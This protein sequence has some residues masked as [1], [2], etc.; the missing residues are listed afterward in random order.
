MVLSLSGNKRISDLPL[1]VQ[2]RMKAKYEGIDTL[3]NSELIALIIGSGT[4]KANALTLATNL[5]ESHITLLNLGKIS[6]PE[7]LLE[8][9]IGEAVALRLL[10]T[11]EIARRI[12]KSYETEVALLYERNSIIR[13]YVRKLSPL[14]KEQ[15]YVLFLN[16]NEIILKEQ[17]LYIGH[18]KGFELDGYEIAKIA[19]TINAKSVILLHNHPSGETYPSVADIETTKRLKSILSSYKLLLKDHFIISSGSYFSFQEAGLIV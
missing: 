10:A 7:A 1:L 3:T 13:K 18:E 8:H 4:K 5:M 9:G 6:M 14:Q 15:L 16:K 17:L 11:F 12:D 19:L 2:P